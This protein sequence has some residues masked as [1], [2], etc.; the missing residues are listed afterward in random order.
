MLRIEEKYLIKGGAEIPLSC[1]LMNDRI[2]RF[3]F[4]DND[5]PVEINAF[6]TI[7]FQFAVFL[8]DHCVEVFS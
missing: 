3:V 6:F 5:Q 2:T 7:E 4:D 8:F 1:V